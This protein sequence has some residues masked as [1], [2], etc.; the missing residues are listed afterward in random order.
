MTQ[1]ARDENP[2]E[3]GPGDWP[4]PR[5]NVLHRADPSDVLP[6]GGKEKQMLPGWVGSQGRGVNQVRQGQL[7]GGGAF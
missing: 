4:V 2:G 1:R 5:I 6:E 7:P 3:P